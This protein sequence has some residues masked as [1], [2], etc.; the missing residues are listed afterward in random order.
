LVV[1][2]RT[3]KESNTINSNEIHKD[4]HVKPN[5]KAQEPEE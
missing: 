4:R 3:S 5:E 2:Y 1:H